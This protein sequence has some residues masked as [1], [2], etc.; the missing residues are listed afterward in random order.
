MKT[1]T[2]LKKVIIENRDILNK[3]IKFIDINFSRGENIKR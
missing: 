3:Y 2:F 1:T